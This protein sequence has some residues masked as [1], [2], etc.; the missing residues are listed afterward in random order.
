MSERLQRGE[1]RVYDYVAAPFDRVSELLRRDALGLFQRAT[2]AAAGRAE[3]VAARLQVGIGALQVG[4]AIEIIIRQIVD[5]KSPFG[6]A[7]T[8]VSIAWQAAHSAAL[9]PSM[10]ASILAYPLSATETQLELQGHYRPPLGLVGAALDS[11]AGHRVAE[12]SVHRFL[13][14]I[15]A[16][17]NRELNPGA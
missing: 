14:E 15:A 11:I 16:Q 10:E 12:A 5:G 9:F 8:V 2:A 4:T 3:T 17:V 1:L 6:D 13:Q 7:A